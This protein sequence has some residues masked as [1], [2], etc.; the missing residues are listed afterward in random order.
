MHLC[1]CA[2]RIWNVLA[3]SFL[4]LLVLVDVLE[5]YFSSH[6]HIYYVGVRSVDIHF[7]L[8]SFGLHSRVIEL[9]VFC[10]MNGGHGLVSGHTK[11]RTA[12]HVN[13][14]R[15]SVRGHAIILAEMAAAALELG[16]G[17][18]DTDAASSVI[19]V[20]GQPPTARTPEIIVALHVVGLQERPSRARSPQKVWLRLGEQQLAHSGVSPARFEKVRHRPLTQIGDAGI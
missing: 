17:A 16:A 14:E 19:C 2:V 12:G 15:L 11:E 18:P 4:I 5:T 20:I 8:G 6:S 7:E 3:G 13:N 1:T 10:D 9:G